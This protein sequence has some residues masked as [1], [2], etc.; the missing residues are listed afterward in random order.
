MIEAD[1]VSDLE[2]VR[3]I[4]RDALVALRQR[5]RTQN[6]E[7]APRRLQPLDARLVHEVDE[8]RRAAVHDRH[9]GAVQ[10]DDRV[11]DPQCGQGREEVFHRLDGHGFARQPGLILDPPEMRDRRR[12]LEAAE[13]RTLEPDPEVRRRRL[14]RQGDFVAGMKSDSG[15]RNRTTKSSLSA[16]DLSDG[17]W[18]S[19]IELSKASATPTPPYK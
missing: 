19:R 4:E 17:T 1:A 7:V 18:E 6:L 16:H 3:R 2:V 5:D 13:I 15:A 12:D 11:V 14:E 9:F 8:G 10:L